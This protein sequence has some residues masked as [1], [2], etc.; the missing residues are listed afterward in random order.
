MKNSGNRYRS[1]NRDT[2]KQLEKKLSLGKRLFSVLSFLR[3]AK[4]LSRWFIIAASVFIGIAII[5]TLVLYTVSSYGENS[6]NIS[7]T[8][9]YDIISKEQVVEM[10]GVNKDTDFASLPISELEKKL[11]NHPAIKEASVSLDS[12]FSLHINIVEHVPLLYVEMADR[13]ITGKATRLCLSHD[14][15][16]FTHD[17]V[18]H[19]KFIDLP[20]WLLKPSDVK[21]LAPG[22]KLDPE[23]CRPI[24]ELA[25]AANTYDDL[26]QL[27]HIVSIERPAENAVQWKML[28]KLET[29][30]TVE[31]SALHDIPAQL[32][33]LIQVLE[34]ARSLD[35]KLISTSVIPEEYIPAVYE[36]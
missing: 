4:R 31:M 1:H 34:H 6:H 8:S 29:G 9:R 22:N 33:R 32:N 30:T 21:S 17:P 5:R 27:P 28:V 20:V 25:R 14:C 11:N 35:K 7:Y 18:F 26:T 23:V 15:T 2:V 19:R 12:S 3:G 24:M 10:L 13:A 16:L 36:Q